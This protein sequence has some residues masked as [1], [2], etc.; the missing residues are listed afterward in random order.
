VTR[1]DTD[2]IPVKYGNKV[3]FWRCVGFSCVLIHTLTFLG[4]LEPSEI[5]RKAV[6]I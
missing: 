6:A 2:L 1:N 4:I 5:I 3:V